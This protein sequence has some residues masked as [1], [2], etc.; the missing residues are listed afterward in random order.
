MGTS[1][2]TNKFTD[3]PASADNY[4][5]THNVVI[6]GLPASVREDIEARSFKIKIKSARQYCEYLNR[7]LDFW[8]EK[9][10]KNVLKDYSGFDKLNEAKREFEMAVTYYTTS[11]SNASLYLERSIKHLV[12]GHVS[13]KTRLAKFLVSNRDKGNRFIEGFV[14]SI[15]KNRGQSLSSNI[16]T[17]EGFV[18]GLQYTKTIGNLITP[19]LDDV[20]EFSNNIQQANDNYSELNAKYTVSFHEQEE[21]IASFSKQTEEQINQMKSDAEQYFA[22]KEKRC[23]DL[24]TLYEEKL[25]LEAPAEYWD[26]LDKKYS[27][28][29]RWWFFFS[30]LFTAAIVF[31]LVLIL[32]HLPN[33]FSEDSHWIDVFKNSAIITV[34]TS[35]A[36]YILRLF[37]KMTMSSFH[38]ARDARERNKLTYFYLSLIE[39]KAVTEKERAIVLN[40]LFSRAD[41]G[42]LKGD[43]S[44]TMSGNV[45]EL[46][47]NLSEK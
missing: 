9:D 21:Q 10:P 22:E 20:T 11:P 46:V 39:K 29:G 45:T 41:T 15:S 17:M 12:D 13:S 19:S 8:R 44:P 43:S 24:E 40:S 30:I 36:V 14:A 5:T 33:L 6:L 1:V 18:A 38:L 32:K 27:V 25:K 34:I 47:K 42:L 2:E 23:K 7:E 28:A 31:G 3:Y 16:D 37:V 26:E 35:V 4:F